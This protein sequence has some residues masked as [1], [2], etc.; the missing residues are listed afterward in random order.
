MYAGFDVVTG[1]VTVELSPAHNAQDF[2]RLMKRIVAQ[3]TGRKKI[4]VV[5]DNAS[6]HTCE[7][8]S[9][10]RRAGADQTARARHR[11]L[12]CTSQPTASAHSR[13]TGEPGRA[14]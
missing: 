14:N 7:E 2:L 13:W 11:P 12:P 10:W 6:V 1:N 9:K 3:Y 8:T 4:H 5:L